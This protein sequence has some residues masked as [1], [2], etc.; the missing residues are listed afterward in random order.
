MSTGQNTTEG[1]TPANTTVTTGNS[2]GR[3][4]D[5][6]DLVQIGSLGSLI[7]RTGENLIAGH[8][9]LNHKMTVGTTSTTVFVSKTVSAAATYWARDYIVIDTFA[10]NPT[11]GRMRSTGGTVDVGRVRVNA[12]G[13]ISIVNSAATVVATSAGTVSIN[14]PF[15]YEFTFTQGASSTAEV[16]VWSSVE[17]DG[18]PT[19]TLTTSAQNFGTANIDTIQ[20]GFT[21]NIT[22]VNAWHDDMAWSDI[23]WIGPAQLSAPDPW[24]VRNSGIYVPPLLIVTGNPQAPVV[25]PTGLP[26]EP[27]V[28]SVPPTAQTPNLLVIGRAPQAPAVPTRPLIVPVPSKTEPQNLLVV[29]RGSLVDLPNPFP[30]QPVTSLYVAPRPLPGPILVQRGSLVDAPTPKPVVALTTPTQQTAP[31]II[32]QRAPQAQVITPTT[33]P[34]EP[35]VVAVP[36]T[37]LGTPLIIAQRAPQAAPVVT[38]TVTP[39]PVVVTQAPT[40]PTAPLI[41]AQRAPQAPPPPTEPLV[42]QT[43]Q[44]A[45]PRNLIFTFRAPQAPAI[46][47]TNAGTQPIVVGTSQTATPFAAPTIRTSRTPVTFVQGAPAPVIVPVPTQPTLGSMLAVLRAPLRSTVDYTVL[48]PPI[49]SAEF[50]WP[51][52]LAILPPGVVC[53]EDFEH[54]CDGTEIPAA[55]SGTFWPMAVGIVHDSNGG[56][57]QE[58]LDHDCAG[59]LIGGGP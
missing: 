9:A 26:A 53:L 43:P 10:S 25:T 58:D 41:I 30:T 12:A 57:C 39:Q 31:L 24:V 15:R 22:S 11:I 13:T 28:V 47:P 21:G 4:G 33:L 5:A 45:Q 48:L 59:N 2:G 40:Q 44:A 6:W 54:A 19:I 8:G 20:F 1:I 14:T 17:S 56:P 55:P 36:Q 51:M 35:L 46:A 3:S 37:Q 42:V 38:P 34:A 52:M 7:S 50:F 49:G 23:G 18:T 29:R 16:R 32:A 27:L